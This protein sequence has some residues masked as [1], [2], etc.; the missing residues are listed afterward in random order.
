MSKIKIAF[1]ILHYN[2]IDETKNCVESIKNHVSLDKTEYIIVIVDNGSPNKSGSILEETYKHDESVKLLMLDK[3]IGFARGNNQGISFVQ[4]NYQTQYICCLN[5]DTLIIKNGFYHLVNESYVKNDRPAVIGP[6]VI[7]K[8]GEIQKYSESLK[9]ISAYEREFTEYKKLYNIKK[10]LNIR[11]CTFFIQKFIQNNI[12]TKKSK[13][14]KTR[15]YYEDIHRDIILHG[16]CL[17]FT[18]EFFK[19]LSGFNESTF[20]YREE[21]LLYIDIIENNI[22]NVYDPNISILHLEDCATNTLFGDNEEKRKFVYK[23]KMESTQIL[24]ERLI[25]IM[26]RREK[27]EIN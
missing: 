20:L 12:E 25:S 17:I 27:N 11:Y 15:D 5:N 1:V 26:D 6:K 16:C 13:N 4:N 14:L 2:A 24:I 23:N 9:T 7:L 10:G 22:H 19:R 21:E 3:N 8:N 18:P